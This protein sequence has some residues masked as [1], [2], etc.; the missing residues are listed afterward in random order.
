MPSSVIAGSDV[1]LV[2]AVQARNN[3][4]LLFF[5]SLWMLSNDAFSYKTPAG[6]ATS[7][8]VCDTACSRESIHVNELHSI[9]V[10]AVL[11]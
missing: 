10:P 7:N 1:V 2:S 4:R 9:I 8:E 6:K 5:G 3:A 11:R